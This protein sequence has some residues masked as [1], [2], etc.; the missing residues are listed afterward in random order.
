MLRLLLIVVLCA[1]VALGQQ[2]AGSLKGQISD[3]FG[4]VI[5]GATVVAVNAS[6]VEKTTT[7]N[8]D[9]N[10]VLNGL[11][12]GKYTI[13][14][15]APGFANN[16]TPD[17]EVLAGR[18]APFNVTLKVTI[19]QQKVTVST[20]GAGVNTEPENNLGAV[21]LKGTDLDSLP[22]DPDDLVA[23][24]QALAGPAA[25][26][27]GGQ[28]YI[29]GFSGGAMPPLSSIREIRINAN[30]FSAEY[31]R[32]GFGRIEILTKPGTDRFRG[33]ASFGFNNQVLNARNPFA[34]TRAAYMS[35]QYG[36][37]LSGPI[38]KKKA[39][40]FVDFEKRDINDDAVIN[41]SILDA[42]LNIVPFS[43]TVPTP[44]RRT[45]F[46]PRI[47]Y[48]INA[49]NTLVARYEYTHNTN[50]AGVGGF[51]LASR[52][53]HTANTE[54]NARVT[55]TAILNKTTVNETRFQFVHQTSGDDANNTIPTIQVSDAFTGGGSQIGL[56]SA[57]TNRWEL[58]N[59]TSR[60]M[61]FHT[62]RFGAR[63][64]DVHITNISPNNF[65]GTWTF[66]SGRTGSGLTSI[67]A[68]QITLR[69]LQN[70]LTPAQIRAQ[71]GGATQF[72]IATGNPKATVSQFDF[73]GFVQDDWRF[74]PNLTLSFGLRY[75]NQ[76]H[77]KSN[78]NLAP[79][80]GFAW[81]V[82]SSN[83]AKPT[84]TVMRGGFGIFYDRV[85]E[86]LTLAASRFNGTNQQQFIVTNPA[87][88][89]SFPTVPS[90]ATLTAFATPVTIDR[91]A[92]DLRTPYTMQLAISVE[93]QLTTSLKVSATYSH[94]RTLHMLRTLAVNA[95]LP[96]TF[97]PLAPNS[98][99]R[100][101][102]SANNI[103]QYDSSGHF[104]QNLLTFNIVNS[105]NRRGSVTV[106]Y[107]FAKANGD[108]DGT[109]SFPAN[110][111]DLSG[112]YGRASSDVRHR[113]TVVGSYRAP[114]GL[115]L[116]PFVIVTS[117]APF[118]ITI[119]RDLNG[120]T[121]FTERPAFASDLTKPGVVVTRFGAFDP[122]PTAGAVIIPRNYG[123]GP[124]SLSANLRIS[125]TF[126]F[127]GERKSTASQ[128]GR[129][130][131]R[132]AGGAEGGGR[133]GFGFPGGGGGA[134]GGRGG[135][136][137]ARGGGGGRGGGLGG[138][139][140]EAG[141]RYN[142]TFSVNFQNILNHTNLGRPT[143]N[144]SSPFFGT[145]TGTGGNF[146]GFGGGRGGGGTPPYNRLI[147]AQVRF[148]F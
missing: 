116:N 49:S 59:I 127:G 65:G 122:N 11:A 58:T 42:N 32:P 84:K 9:G 72:S 93:R 23:A 106:N 77:I 56:A 31:D 37:N 104:D 29:D 132:G 52:K 50:V 39:S 55:E 133:G 125:K 26:P 3:E 46:S 146:A 118:N 66:A 13:K 95:P 110:S 137:A 112:E 47:D 15:T 73:G 135:G 113:L 105:F 79:R 117:G 27:N 143:G 85:G 51:S 119:G 33:Q 53:Y 145:S 131:G 14:V 136:G 25:G 141:Q 98:G 20:D 71:G 40:F 45:E 99:V 19:E 121:V 60:V 124:G 90:I 123:Q 1:G 92:S 115:S 68:Y 74:R 17:L 147:D 34:P 120:D 76:T 103:F 78:F 54:Q 96:G 89:D 111:Y 48:Q 139:G 88:L 69:G 142:L 100:P 64:R 7:T 21:V 94:A 61:G 67:Q 97:N 24:L 8:G 30:P 16:E 2:S 75:E 41:G 130:G 134:G 4:G 140:A 128:P 22:D 35:R 5:V 87:V 138:N 102:G 28:I 148:T 83:S 44:N 108:T 129:D 70:G 62:L 82:G 18:T 126:G 6:G 57:D 81:G 80:L 12:P 43:D 10:F 109:G 101:F 63:L 36:G 86:N 144:L 107:S 38:F 114:W 91:L